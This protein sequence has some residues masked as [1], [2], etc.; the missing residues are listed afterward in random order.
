MN[1]ILK[2]ITTL[3][4]ITSCTTNYRFY[5]D[6][7]LR[8]KIANI[9]LSYV[10]KTKIMYNG[11]YYDFDCS[12]F[13]KFVLLSAGI[14]IDSKVNFFSFSKTVDYYNI[15][16]SSGKL[17]KEGIVK[18]GDLVF[19]DNTYDRNGNKLFDDKLTHVGIVVGIDEST[20]SI[21]FVDKSRGNKVS[22]KSLNLAKR[23][24]HKILVDGVSYEINSYVRDDNLGKFLA[25][26]VF[27]GF[28]DISVLFE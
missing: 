26:S 22:L 9:A 16:R 8:V 1:K 27:A 4:V 13:V 5:D 12:G 3:L 11:K 6:R 23:D 20:K 17:F 24:V 10:G 15:F 28:G 25:S 7:D 19:F 21:F 2:V 18:P 14:D